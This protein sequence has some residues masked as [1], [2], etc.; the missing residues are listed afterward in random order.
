M[1][2]MDK[3]KAAAGVG[4]ASMQVDLKQR[5]SRRGEQLVAVIRVIGG[6]TNT[7]LNY[8]VA[9]FR[10]IGKWTIQSSNG[11]PIEIEGTAIFYRYNQPG[12]EGVVL[13]AG[14]TLEFPVTITVPPDAPLTSG[15]LKFDFGVRADLEGTADPS[16]NTQLEIT[17]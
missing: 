16:Y 5:P 14:K 6:K 3:M 1:G 17:G 2:L 4:A 7:K 9:D 11:S 8:V 13:E 10:W 12:S 15:T